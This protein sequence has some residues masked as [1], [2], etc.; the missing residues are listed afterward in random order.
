MGFVVT[1]S[2]SGARRG[3]WEGVRILPWRTWPGRG[4]DAGRGPVEGLR[5]RLGSHHGA[6][7]GRAVGREG[8]LR[9]K[10]S[11]GVSWT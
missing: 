1:G 10:R 9:G 11:E 5:S 6:W 3:A 4:E 2:L 8:L 7:K